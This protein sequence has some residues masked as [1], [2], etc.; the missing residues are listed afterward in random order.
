MI[1]VL[2]IKVQHY[3]IIID[4]FNDTELKTTNTVIINNISKQ[5][6]HDVYQM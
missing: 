3:Q 1:Y 2:N 4:V 5:S 6:K